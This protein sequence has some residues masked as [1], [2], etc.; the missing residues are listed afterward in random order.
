[1]AASQ[2]SMP[3]PGISAASPETR[4]EITRQQFFKGRPDVSDDRLERR[5][6]QADE[7]R[8]F[9]QEETKPV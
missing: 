9:K 2:G 5:Q 7:L 1:M 8:K 4:R 3:T 6:K